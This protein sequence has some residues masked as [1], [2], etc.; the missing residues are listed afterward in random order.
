M[1]VTL[2]NIKIKRV[3]AAVAAVATMATAGVLSTAAPASAS[4]GPGWLTVC[5]YGN[6]ASYVKFPERGG[7]S[8]YL[9][10]KGDCRDFQVGGN[11]TIE[12]I[13]VRGVYNTSGNTFSVQKG[14]FRGSKG[15]VVQTYGT[16]AAGNHWAMVPS[17]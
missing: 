5:S 6:Y 17:V 14:S 13:E 2:K 1:Q 16:T 10:N 11:T 9:V 7:Y 15:G 3:A 8:T 12:P 4:T